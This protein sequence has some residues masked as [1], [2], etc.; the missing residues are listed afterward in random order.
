MENQPV[1]VYTANITGN[2]TEMADAAGLFKLLW[3]PA[4]LGHDKAKDL[5]DGLER[6]LKILKGDPAYFKEFNS[7]NGWGDYEDL[8]NFVRKYLD[9]CKENPNTKIQIS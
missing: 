4:E 5:I 9:A 3:K 8:L 6:G 7:K 1:E 2:L